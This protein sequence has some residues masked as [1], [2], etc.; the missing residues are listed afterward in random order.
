MIDIFAQKFLF[1]ILIDQ[2]DRTRTSKCQLKLK[3]DKNIFNSGIEA[4][5]RFDSCFAKQTFDL[6][7]I[8]LKWE[9]NTTTRSKHELVS[10]IPL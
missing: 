3:Q 6:I 2:N 7:F 9:C 1:L 10:M 4:C 5:C 8:A